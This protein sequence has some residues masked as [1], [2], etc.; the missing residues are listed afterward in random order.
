MAV[1]ASASPPEIPT[2]MSLIERPPGASRSTPRGRA[3]SAPH[4]TFVIGPPRSGTTLLASLLCHSPDAYPLLPE[5]TLL[6]SALR[7]RVEQ[8]N[9]GADRLRHSLYART[10]RRL[11]EQYAQLASWILQNTVSRFRKPRSHLVLKDPHL[12]FIANDLSR[13]IRPPFGSVCLVRDPRDV[14]ASQMI[15][16][17]KL[18]DGGD[19]GDAWAG[20][21]PFYAALAE[22]LDAPSAGNP[23]LCL[24]YEDLVLDAANARQDLQAF[25]GYHLGLD[26]YA[27]HPARIFNPDD[28]WFQTTLLGPITEARIGAYRTLLTEDQTQEV[29]GQ[30]ASIMA[31]FGYGR[32][33]SRRSVVVSA[34]AIWDV[35]SPQ[36]AEI[37][38]V[39]MAAKS[40]PKP[41]MT[42]LDA[43]ENR[44]RELTQRLEQAEFET[45]L[46]RRSIESERAAHGATT[47]RLEVLHE[48]FAADLEDARRRSAEDLDYARERFRQELVETQ[49]RFEGE[50][51]GIRARAAEADAQRDRSAEALAAFQAR[52][53][54]DL[55]EYGKRVTEAKAHREELALELQALRTKA[56]A[57]LAEAQQSAAT[58]ETSRREASRLQKACDAKTEEA[59][60]AVAN[61]AATWEDRVAA[62]EFERDIAV[63]R[64]ATLESR[65]LVRWLRPP[66]WNDKPKPPA[67]PSDQ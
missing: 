35:G 15:V 42:A 48:A 53:E 22:A 6:T 39:G 41:E 55:D 58:A 54:A 57:S 33:D 56:E 1:P 49:E 45:E 32:S 60:T 47:R 3:G 9:V 16:H 30:F 65:F 19:F 64:L 11:D 36:F 67:A 27:G 40:G 4:I 38:D 13:F 51:A 5:C 8:L 50:L 28:P 46:V 10:D 52:Y 44:C 18:G 25:C 61:A 29:E 26:R 24:R 59:A 34:A 7:H 20:V 43:A 23:R 31:R 17:R 12:C 14:V 21:Y 66:G 62:L 37:E 63:A 2:D